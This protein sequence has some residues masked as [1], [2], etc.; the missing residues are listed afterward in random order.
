MTFPGEDIFGAGGF[1]L[2]HDKVLKEGQN[3]GMSMGRM[4]SYYYR[5]MLSIAPIAV[6]HADIGTE[7]TVLWGDP[8]TRQK[9]IRVTVA[10]Y[11]YLD[12]ERNEAIDTSTIPTLTTT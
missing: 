1:T 6:E 5:V 4:Y 9:E 11:P 2:F 10:R 12:L 7:L 8:D 3:V